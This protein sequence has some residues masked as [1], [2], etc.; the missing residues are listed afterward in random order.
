MSALKQ[1]FVRVHLRYEQDRY[2]EDL[3][4]FAAWLI[5]TRYQNKNARRHLFVVYSRSCTL[6]A[7]RRVPRCAADVLERAFAK[8]A[9]AGRAT[10]PHQRMPVTC[11]PAAD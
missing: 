3:E 7:P 4:R 8:L 6:S 2:A 10:T 11:A 5:A 9:D 1:V